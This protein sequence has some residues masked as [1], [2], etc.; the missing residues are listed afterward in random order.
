MRNP[1]DWLMDQ[2]ERIPD[3]V[4]WVLIVVSSVGGSI[5]FGWLATT[6]PNP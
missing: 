2:V 1:L 4:L 6:V 3:R 5:I